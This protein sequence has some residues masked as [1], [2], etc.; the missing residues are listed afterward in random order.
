MKIF[1]NVG[2]MKQYMKKL[3]LEL[4]VIKKCDT[5]TPISAQKRTPKHPFFIEALTLSSVSSS[6]TLSKILNA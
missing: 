4:T 1:L 6:F 5:A 3:T 2:D